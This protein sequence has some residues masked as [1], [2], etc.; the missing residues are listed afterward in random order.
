MKGNTPDSSDI[1]VTLE[2]THIRVK[3]T[4]Q[5]AHVESNGILCYYTDDGNIYAKGF[6][7]SC[8]APLLYILVHKVNTKLLHTSYMHTA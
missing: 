4:M 2:C 6:A 3:W 8:K 7:L 5:N 1:T